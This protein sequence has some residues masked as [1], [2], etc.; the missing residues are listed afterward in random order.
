MRVQKEWVK[1]KEFSEQELVRREKVKEISKVC[2]PYPE[3]YER[4][5]RLHEAILAFFLWNFSTF[6]TRKIMVR[7]I[8]WIIRRKRMVTGRLYK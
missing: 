2:N 7:F 1:V 8:K 6:C 5:H 4:T 3:R